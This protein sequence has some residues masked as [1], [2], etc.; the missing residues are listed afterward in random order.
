[1]N[2][3]FGPFTLASLIDKWSRDIMENAAEP[4]HD[5][6]SSLIS[7]ISD[8]SEDISFQLHSGIMKAARRV[9]IDEI[10][11]SMIPDFI[12]LKKTQKNLRPKPSNQ[13]AKVCYLD[14]KRGDPSFKNNYL[15]F[16]DPLIPKWLV[17]WCV[18]SV[19]P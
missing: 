1:M 6:F 5:D 18:I 19:A 14:V 9:L 17:F 16:C 10:I 3:K 7:F 4:V 15:C 12:A 13:V 2:N 11:S 8:I